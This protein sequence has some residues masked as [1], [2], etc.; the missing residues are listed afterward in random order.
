MHL[1][2]YDIHLDRC[3][4]CQRCLAVCPVGA[5]MM[6]ETSAP[7][8]HNQKCRRCGACKKICKQQAISRRIRLQF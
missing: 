2:Q 3:M 5:I 4:R 8:I 6:T 7:E 1:K